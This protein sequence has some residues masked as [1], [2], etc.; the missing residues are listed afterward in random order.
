MYREI[1]NESF[2]IDLKTKQDFYCSSC[3]A[4][5]YLQQLEN[6]DCKTEN[7]DLKKTLDLMQKS[8]ILLLQTVDFPADC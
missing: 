7:Q 2:S 8:L 5:S 4:N 3:I 6:I 1:Y